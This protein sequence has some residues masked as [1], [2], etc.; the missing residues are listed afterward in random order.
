MKCKYPVYNWESLVEKII[1]C[2]DST[3]LRVEDVENIEIVFHLNIK[4][5]FAFIFRLADLAILGCLAF[6]D[7]SEVSRFIFFEGVPYLTK[8]I[9]CI[10]I[11]AIFVILAVRGVS[12]VNENRLGEGEN[13]SSA[14]F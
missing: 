6:R 7:N 13:R 1:N 2:L 10:S 12:K 8:F 9:V 11:V 5:I 4:N 14:K 3:I